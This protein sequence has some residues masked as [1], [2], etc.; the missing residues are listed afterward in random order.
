[1]I[2]KS[3]KLNI[4]ERV[5]GVIRRLV[6]VLYGEQCITCRQSV[7]VDALDEQGRCASC[8]KNYFGMQPIAVRGGM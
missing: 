2:Q 7:H 5:K 3:G 6:V 8:L 4:S 1:M